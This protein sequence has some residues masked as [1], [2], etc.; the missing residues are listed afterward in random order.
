MIQLRALPWLKNRY[1]WLNIEEPLLLIKTPTLDSKTTSDLPTL[2]W[3]TQH[4]SVVPFLTPVVL[5]M[6]VECRFSEFTGNYFRRIVNSMT[7]TLP[8]SLNHSFWWHAV[9]GTLFSVSKYFSYGNDMVIFHHC[10]ISDLDVGHLVFIDALTTAFADVH[11][12]QIPT[13]LLLFHQLCWELSIDS[14]L[15]GLQ[16]CMDGRTSRCLV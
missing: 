8:T 15:F 14:S 11:G 3:N 10:P 9:P 6:I 1:L 7:W 13:S 12:P 16:K 5:W 4:T 2:A